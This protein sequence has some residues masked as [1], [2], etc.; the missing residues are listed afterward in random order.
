MEKTKSQAGRVAVVTGS[1]RGIGLGIATRLVDMGAFV[2]MNGRGAASLDA[3]RQGLEKGRGKVIAV[4]GDVGDPE[5]VERL[6][7][8][9][10]A[11]Y[12]RVD[13]LVNNAALANPVAHFLE[14]EP[15]RWDRVIR[16]NLTSVY[17]CS[18]L[19][20]RSMVDQGV[21]G[22]IVNISSFGATR[23][24]RSLTAYDAA[25]GGVEALTRAM[26]L[27]LAP[28][29]IRVNA[30]APGP[31][32]TA[33]AG[34]DTRAAIRRRAALVPLGRIGQ[35]DDVAGAVVFLASEDAA[36]ITGQTLAVDGGMLVQLRPAGMD[37]ALPPNVA[38]RIRPGEPDK[39]GESPGSG[40]P[41]RK[42]E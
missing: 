16:A 32:L 25:K 13:L 3:A 40:L 30:V 22:S 39:D 21:R 41:G 35:P 34:S 2:V 12:G 28:F 18:R 8:T 11:E 26:A 7:S 10:L 36:F 17:L 29:G 20:A 9:T 14:L 19:A 33:G 5:D 31:I 1:S 42:Q 24:H 38:Q 15:T 6:F 4:A 23:A 37:T 27:D